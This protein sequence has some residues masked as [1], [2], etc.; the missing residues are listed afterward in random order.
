MAKFNFTW[1]RR[2]AKPDDSRGQVD[3]RD[4]WR[5]RGVSPVRC[6]KQIESSGRN[7]E[8]SKRAGRTFRTRAPAVGGPKWAR[9]GGGPAHDVSCR[10][11]RLS[12]GRS[13]A[14][15]SH[16]AGRRTRT[17]LG[18]PSSARQVQPV[19]RTSQAGP[20]LGGR[21]KAGDVAGPCS[22][23][24]PARARAVG[25]RADFWPGGQVAWRANGARL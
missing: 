18:A 10:R 7:V 6:G 25:R 22:C 13:G 11:R 2:P 12:D 15:G 5:V 4:V 20:A 3:G 23:R 17:K 24:W 21:I 8:N 14:H 19:A 9:S 16:A 1:T